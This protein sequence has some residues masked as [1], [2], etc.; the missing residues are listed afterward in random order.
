MEPY[1]KTCYLGIK[2]FKLIIFP[3]I[4]LIKIGIIGSGD[5]GRRLVDGLLDLWHQVKI[6]TRDTSKKEDVEWINKHRKTGGK[7]SE[8]ESI[9][10][11]S[12]AASFGASYLKN[13]PSDDV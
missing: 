13:K 11:F 12:E 10:R 2:G 3:Q 1:Q 6:G 7:E 8:N 9:G 4:I 5:V